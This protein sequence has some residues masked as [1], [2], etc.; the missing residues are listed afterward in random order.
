MKKTRLLTAVILAFPDRHQSPGRFCMPVPS[1]AANQ[2]S[3]SGVC[4]Q[5]F[6]PF[7]CTLFKGLGGGG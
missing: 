4:L 3:G 5:S 2:G 7:H 6:C 1:W